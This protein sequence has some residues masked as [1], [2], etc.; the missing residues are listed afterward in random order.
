MV[1]RLVHPNLADN[2]TICDVANYLLKVLVFILLQDLIEA[3][4]TNVFKV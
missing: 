3:Y 1:I 2:K 4:A